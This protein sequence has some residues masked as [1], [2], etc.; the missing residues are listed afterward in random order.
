MNKH[1]PVYRMCAYTRKSFLKSDLFRVVRIANKVYFD[2]NQ[3]MPGRGAYLSKNIEVIQGALTKKTLS[4]AL[5]ID[6]KE[7]I[8]LEMINALSEER[9]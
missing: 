3:N 5:K 1:A 8:Y 6:V 4:K 7:E 9:R 2:K